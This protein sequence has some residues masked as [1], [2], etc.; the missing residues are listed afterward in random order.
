MAIKTFIK[1]FNS[2]KATPQN[3]AGL[4]LNVE[5]YKNFVPH[6]SHSHILNKQDGQIIAELIIS[7]MKFEV[8]YTSKIIYEINEK[9]AIIYVTEYSS[10]TFK[11]LYNKWNIIKTGDEEV[12]INFE[13]EFQLSNKILNLI[14]GAS[15]NVV[16]DIILDAFIK[17]AKNKIY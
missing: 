16:A 1:K 17:H 10:K 7:F 4:I 9:E 8:P 15:L 2:K 14:A 13:V 6:V 12:T 5:D 3:L 11:K